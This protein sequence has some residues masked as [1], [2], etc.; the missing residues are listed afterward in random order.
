MEAGSLSASRAPKLLLGI[1]LGLL[2]ALIA[3]V[4]AIG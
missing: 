4:L 3:L 2:A 1:P